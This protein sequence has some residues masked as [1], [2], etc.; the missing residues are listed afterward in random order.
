[1]NVK[2]AAAIIGCSITHC[3]ELIRKEKLKAKKKPLILNGVE[4]GYRWDVRR[5]DA[6]RYRDRPKPTTGIAGFPMGKKR[7]SDGTMKGSQLKKNRPQK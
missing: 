5:E 1:M 4:S 2:D 3:R 7:R 6:E